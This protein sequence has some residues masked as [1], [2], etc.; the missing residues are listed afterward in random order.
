MNLKASVAV[1]PAFGHSL[2]A[3]RGEGSVSY[4]F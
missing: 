2:L 4:R 3:Q 1:Q